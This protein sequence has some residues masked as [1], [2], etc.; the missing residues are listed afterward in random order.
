MLATPPLE[1]KKKKKIKS[2][3]EIIRAFSLPS[4]EH[5]KGFLSKYTVLKVKFITGQS[6][7][8]FGDVRVCVCVCVCTTDPGNVTGWGSEGVKLFA[9]QTYG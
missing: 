6:N 1:E 8:L 4:H 2:K 7:I 9:L 5:L 3:F